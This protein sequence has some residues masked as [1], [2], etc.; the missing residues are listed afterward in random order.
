MKPNDLKDLEQITLLM[1]AGDASRKD[2]VAL[3]ILLREYLSKINQP[4]L[5]DISHCVAH[6]RRDRGQAY[7]YIDSFLKNFIKVVKQGG[8]FEVGV[9]FPIQEVVKELTDSLKNVGV[10]FADEQ[11]LLLQS[12]HIMRLMKDILVGVEVKIAHLNVLKCTFQA[13]ISNQGEEF[14]FIVSFTGLEKTRGLRIP[15][16]VAIGFP[17]FLDE[18]VS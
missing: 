18:P 8:A 12:D 3:L 4:M 16:N 7:D 13:G 2:M 15:A 10:V 14:G 6:S 1:Q 9:L 17:V 11:T 5:L